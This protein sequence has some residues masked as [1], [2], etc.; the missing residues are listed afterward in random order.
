[1]SGRHRGGIAIRYNVFADRL[2]SSVGV[3]DGSNIGVVDSSNI[4][5]DDND[6]SS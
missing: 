2:Y 6:S 3:V 1:M 4:G 5:V